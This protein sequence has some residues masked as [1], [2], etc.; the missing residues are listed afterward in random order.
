M[1]SHYNFI[2]NLCQV[3]D[4]DNRIPY[5]WYQTSF[6]WFP[7]VLSQYLLS[8][9]SALIFLVYSLCTLIHQGI[10]FGITLVIMPA[11]D[12]VNFLKWLEGTTSEAW[13]LIQNHK[14]LY[15]S[16]NFNHP[17][18]T[19]AILIHFPVQSNRD[20][21]RGG[22]SPTIY[23]SKSRQGNPSPPGEASLGN[24]RSRRLSHHHPVP[25]SHAPSFRWHPIS[26]SSTR[27]C[28]SETLKSVLP[29]ETGE[30]WVRSPSCSMGYH[31]NE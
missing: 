9:M 7:S 24:D 11:F 5:R 25:R 15:R 23:P 31:R 29:I 20:L 8:G 1:L 6:I 22:R 19:I 14:C 27:S 3:Y 2:A 18:R 28:G 12:P 26:F 10:F 4:N 16:A 21:Y 30:V 17:N 13:M